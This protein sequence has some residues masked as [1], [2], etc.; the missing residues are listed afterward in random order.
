MDALQKFQETIFTL[1]VDEFEEHALELFRWQATHN[2]VY[3]NY[4]HQLRINPETVGAVEQIPFLPIDFF[5]HHAILSAADT[6]VEVVFES[7]GTTND[8][9]SHHHVTDLSFY[10]RVSQRIF[11]DQF[12][13]LSSY[14]IL[15]LLPSYLERKNASLVAMVEHFIQESDSPYGGFYLNDYAAL[16]Q[17]LASTAREGRQVLLIGVT[18]ALL[19]LAEAYG[20]DLSQVTVIETGGMKGMR[21]ELIREEVYDILRTRTGARRL[22]SEYGMTELLSQAYSQEAN[23][24]RLPTW[25][26]VLAREI[27]D[28]FTWVGKET[29]GGMNIIDLA[30]VHSCAFIETM[31]RGKVHRDGTFEVLGRLDNSDI[32][33]CNTMVTS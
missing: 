16:V 21:K 11:E 24:F 25:M 2:P 18:F 22:C 23:V 31:D 19:Q 6:S 8:A 28:P 5:K 12:G 3:R 20:P 14:H 4:I 7:S 13:P 1:S 26:R 17:A 33:G 9:R 30:N 27:N 10:H 15:A 32:R 29:V